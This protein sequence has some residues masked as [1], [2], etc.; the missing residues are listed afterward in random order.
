MGFIHI[1]LAIRRQLHL[2]FTIFQILHATPIALE[3]T[4]I[5][6]IPMTVVIEDFRLEVAQMMFLY[7][8]IKC[9][10]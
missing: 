1:L 2:R 8:N 6:I 3:A 7:L 9:H 4:I 5:T 10:E